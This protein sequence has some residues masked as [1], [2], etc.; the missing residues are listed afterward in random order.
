[1]TAKVIED[2]FL[3]RSK[4][5]Q[6][7]VEVQRSDVVNLVI[8]DELT[9]ADMMVIVEVHHLENPHVLLS[10]VA[11]Q[12]CISSKSLELL[13]ADL[14]ICGALVHVGEIEASQLIL[15]CLSFV[16]HGTVRL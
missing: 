16:G 1:V 13:P 6:V 3:D 15:V 12:S 4:G 14:L 5:R 11:S 7:A 10:R 2:L 8:S 9:L